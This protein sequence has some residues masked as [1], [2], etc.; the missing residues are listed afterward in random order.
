MGCSSGEMLQMGQGR[1]LSILELHTTLAIHYVL[2]ERD[3]V[4]DERSH[5]SDP[6]GRVVKLQCSPNSSRAFSV[7][8][9]ITTR[10]LDSVDTDTGMSFAN[11]MC[12]PQVIP[13]SR[14]RMSMS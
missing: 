10:S 9:L 5:M 3:I 7:F 11:P 1:A 14:A 4:R 8:S 13:W 12:S 6:S 2:E